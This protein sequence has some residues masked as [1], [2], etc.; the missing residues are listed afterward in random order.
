M[1]L[2]QSTHRIQET[3]KGMPVRIGKKDLKGEEVLVTVSITVIC[4]MAKSSPGR[5]RLI[6]LTLPGNTPSLR[7]VRADK[8]PGGKG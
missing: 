7:E 3:R 4:T 5:K 6:P 1:C 2:N 8:E